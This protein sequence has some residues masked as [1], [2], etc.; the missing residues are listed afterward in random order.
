MVYPFF[1]RDYQVPNLHEGATS[2]GS[3]KTTLRLSQIVKEVFATRSGNSTFVAFGLQMG[4]PAILIAWVPTFFTG[5]MDWIR[6][7]R[8]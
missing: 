1:V 2:N 8:L 7:R 5:S 4:I 3:G 6:R